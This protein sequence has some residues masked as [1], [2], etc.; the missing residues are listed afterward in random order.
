MYKRQA[1]Q[2]KNLRTYVHAEFRT[3]VFG[4]NDSAAKKKLPLQQEAFPCT[5]YLS[6]TFLRF[7]RVFYLSKEEN[8]EQK[9]SRGTIST[10]YQ[11][12]L[13]RN[14]PDK[15]VQYSNQNSPDISGQSGSILTPVVLI[16]TINTV[17]L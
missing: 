1:Q 6:D 11:T 10:T 16:N 4:A 5:C 14:T 7:H 17:L 2:L 13:K 3:F 9:Q 15:V 12:V 8:W